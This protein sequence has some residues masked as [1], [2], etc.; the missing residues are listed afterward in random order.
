MSNLCIYHANCVDGFGS[1]TALYKAIPDAEFH[2][3][4]YGEEP[5]KCVDKNVYLVDFSYKRSVVEE[6][7]KTA[8]SVTIIDHHKSAILDLM[9]LSHPNLIKCFSANHSGA[10]M[11]WVYFFP[12]EPVPMLLQ[13]IED[14]DLWQFKLENT[15]EVCATLYSHEFEFDQWMT[16]YEDLKPLILEGRA[17]VRSRNKAI[18]QMLNHKPEIIN[19]GGYDVPVMNV[20]PSIASEVAQ[21]LAQ[22][23]DFKFG[24]V[25]HD[26]DGYRIFSLR[27]VNGFDVS[28]VAVTYGG[29]GHK[30]AA[31]FR[32]KLLPMLI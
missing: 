30:S 1:A 14:R 2:A 29:G 28:E 5:P 22:S 7:L 8:R 12:Y 16:F 15:N 20:S 13:H 31:G 10:V 17:L 23:G 19:I 32:I 4:V 6:M 25:Y 9:D 24:A 27:S 11:T 26:T 3:G 18:R 21:G